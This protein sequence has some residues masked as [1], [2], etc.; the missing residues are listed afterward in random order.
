MHHTCAP[1]TLPLCAAECQLDFSTFSE[2]SGGKGLVVQRAFWATFVRRHAFHAV[3]LEFRL[4]VVELVWEDKV[5][6]M[7]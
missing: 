5:L 7:S 2:R 3:L 1:R 6:C 4:K